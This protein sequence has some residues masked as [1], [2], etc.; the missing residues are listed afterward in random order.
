MLDKKVRGINK[1]KYA[2]LKGYGNLAI[3]M[4][5]LEEIVTHCV[6]VETRY[7][8]DRNESFLSKVSS[9]KDFEVITGDEID[10]TLVQQSLEGE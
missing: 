5:L 4:H 3:P 9:I 2:V 10:S 1:T 8:S 6:L 7:D